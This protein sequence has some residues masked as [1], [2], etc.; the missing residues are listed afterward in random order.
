ML[1]S[2]MFTPEKNNR[3]GALPYALFPRA[4]FTIFVKFCENAQ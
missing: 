4:G 1:S 3:V 2:S